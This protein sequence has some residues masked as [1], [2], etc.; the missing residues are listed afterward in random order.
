MMAMSRSRIYEHLGR[1]PGII[2]TG[3]SANLLL[4][5]CVH[6]ILE[7]Q[8]CCL[9]WSVRISYIQYSHYSSQST[10]HIFTRDETGLV[11]PC[12]FS[13]SVHCNFTGDG[14][15]NERGWACNPP[16]SPAWANFTLMMECS[17]ESSRCYSVY[18][19][20]QLL[21]F[22]AFTVRYTCDYLGERFTVRRPLADCVQK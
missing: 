11:C 12:P 20:P 17:P 4:Y 22:P 15:C 21:L 19:V 16:P 3:K 9:A 6:I 1:N 10:V 2:F 18:T 7:S 5:I 13:W 8:S 14:K